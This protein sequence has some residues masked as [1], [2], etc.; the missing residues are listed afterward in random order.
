ML[1][2]EHNDLY[3]VNGY[4]KNMSKQHITVVTLAFKFGNVDDCLN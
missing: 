1:K 4:A 2:I 3:P